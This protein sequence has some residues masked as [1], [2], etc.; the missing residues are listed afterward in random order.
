[1]EA[2][3]QAKAPI[4][5]LFHLPYQSNSPGPRSSAGKTKTEV[6]FIERCLDLL[7]PGGRLGIVL[8]E[9]VFNSP[10]LA[11]VREY[12]ENRMRIEAV[13]SLPQEAFGA[14][15][16]TVKTSLL[17]ARK[18]YEDERGAYL[19]AL[20]EAVVEV[21]NERREAVREKRA[22]LEHKIK[23][24]SNADARKSAQKELRDFERK[25]T[26]EQAAEARRRMKV[27][28]D[29][30]VFLYDAKRV[31]I[32]ATGESD[33]CELFDTRNKDQPLPPGMAPDDTALALYQAFRIDP[34]SFLLDEARTVA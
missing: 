10:S 8:P 28:H 20:G 1:V 16:T 14:S 13:V 32:T 4:A 22:R 5:S 2:A 27:A 31:G 12:C 6:L 15:G 33:A 34:A 26:A 23:N 29:Y 11:Y 24:A 7:K 19:H 25:E 17:F 3:A 9:G 21:A 30:P 18:L